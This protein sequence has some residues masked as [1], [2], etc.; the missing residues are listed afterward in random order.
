VVVNNVS[1]RLFAQATSGSVIAIQVRDDA[2]ASSTSGNV[3]LEQV[4]GRATARSVCGWGMVNDVGGDVQADST[5]DNVTVT[6]VRGRVNAGSI[7]GAII[8]RQASEGVRATAVSGKIEISDSKGRMDV[9][10]TSDSITLNNVDSRGIIAKSTSGNVHF[11]GKLYE[12][13]HYE[14]ESFSSNVVLIL[15]PDSNLTLT[16]RSHSGSI[17]TEFPLQIAPGITNRGRGALSGTIGKGGAEVRA[18]TFSGSVFIKK[19]AGQ[20]K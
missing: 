5:S 8:I 6:N 20:T 17:N 12:E 9:N 7:S 2:T 15:P 18:A 1:S 10:T 13:G 19:N 4:G 16:T 3:K 14:F 11:A